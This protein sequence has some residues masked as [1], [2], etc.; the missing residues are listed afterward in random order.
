[1]SA[2]AAVSGWPCVRVAMRLRGLSMCVCVHEGGLGSQGPGIWMEL[3]A[4]R[5]GARMGGWGAPAGNVSCT[6]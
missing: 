6:H 5:A 1:M 2:C 3:G 4:A